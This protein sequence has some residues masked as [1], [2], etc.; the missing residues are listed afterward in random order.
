[1]QATSVFGIPNR[2]S[3]PGCY[4]PSDSPQPLRTHVLQYA[5]GDTA[6]LIFSQFKDEILKAKARTG[7]PNPIVVRFYERGIE[8]NL[9]TYFAPD[10]PCFTYDEAAMS[11]QTK[12]FT[13]EQQSTYQQTLKKVAELCKQDLLVNNLLLQVEKISD[14][15]NS[16]I[17]QSRVIAQM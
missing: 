5:A 17:L 14:L 9:V 3:S 4:G 16:K 11:T 7:I 8:C 15:N 12:A 6:T 2:S 10:A 13:P 1:M